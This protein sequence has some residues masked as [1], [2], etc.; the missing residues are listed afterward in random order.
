MWSL[1][2]SVILKPIR[3]KNNDEMSKN[4]EIKLGLNETDGKLGSLVNLGANAI[5]FRLLPFVSIRTSI[6]SFLAIHIYNGSVWCGCY[7]HGV[8]DD[9]LTLL[10][11]PNPLMVPIMVFPN[12]C[13]WQIP[14]MMNWTRFVTRQIWFWKSRLKQLSSVEICLYFLL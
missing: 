8:T 12:P 9:G 3:N 13:R 7:R 2:V 1:P 10:F 5:I 14:V 6:I 4:E 11:R